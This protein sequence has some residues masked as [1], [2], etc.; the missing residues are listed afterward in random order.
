MYYKVSYFYKSHSYITS[1]VISVLLFIITYFT[2]GFYYG[3][4]DDVIQMNYLRGIGLAKPAKQMFT[5]Q[6]LVSKLYHYLYQIGP[7]IPWYGYFA[8]F[9][10]FIATTQ[11][12]FILSIAF[13]KFYEKHFLFFVL[14]VSFFY[15]IFWIDFVVLISF[16]KTAILLVGLSILSLDF[17]IKDKFSKSERWILVFSNSILL[18]L[19][20]LNRTEVLYLWIVPL[21]IYVWRYKSIEAYKVVALLIVLT[22]ASFYILKSQTDAELQQSIR[23]IAHI[24][25]VTDGKNTWHIPFDQLVE[26]DF[27]YKSAYYY[28]WPDL[29]IISDEQLHKWGPEKVYSLANLKNLPTKLKYEVGRAYQGYSKEYSKRLNWWFDFILLSTLNFLI[30]IFIWFRNKRGNVQLLVHHTLFLLAIMGLLLLVFLFYKLESRVVLPSMVLVTLVS[31]IT[32]SKL[33]NF[34]TDRQFKWILA[35]VCVPIVLYQVGSYRLVA[36]DRYN[37]EV[38]K[39]KFISEMNYNYDS[40]VILFDIWSLSLLHSSFF[41]SIQLNPS[42]RYISHF[43]SWSNFVPGNIAALN[44][45]CPTTNFVSFYECIAE[46]KD[47]FVFV[48]TKNHRLTFIA[49]YAKKMHSYELEFEEIFPESALSRI[50]YSFM[51]HKFDFG[52][53]MLRKFEKINN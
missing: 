23:K 52:Y 15:F 48:M 46:D 49:E 33:N 39:K 44:T 28:Y 47:R 22:M 3:W 26:K 8:F 16:T 35:L 7:H 11:L 38:L 51:P 45:I 2:F 14:L 29:S 19:G 9:Y 5:N 12:V 13:R 31:F 32:I 27:L 37:E 1:V 20:V 43:E 25:N 41:E 53:F 4:I 24:Q 42:N 50:H 34:K 18:L 36:A 30:C 21:M 17:A 10:I 6:V 40:K